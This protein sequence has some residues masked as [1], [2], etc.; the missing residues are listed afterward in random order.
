MQ[1]LGNPPKDLVGD[2]DNAIPIPDL[3]TGGVPD[4]SQCSIM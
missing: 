4:P 3:T 1:E 2:V